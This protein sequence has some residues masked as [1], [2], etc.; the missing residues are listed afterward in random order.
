MSPS[1]LDGVGANKQKKA[2]KLSHTVKE[3]SEKGTERAG[4]GFQA[5]QADEMRECWDEIFPNAEQK[6][7][8]NDC[9]FC[10]LVTAALSIENI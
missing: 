6:V 1:G 10:F 8:K 7:V 2:N 9:H 3:R 4:L 5:L